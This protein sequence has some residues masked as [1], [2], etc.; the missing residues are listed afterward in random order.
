[1]LSKSSSAFWTSFASSAPYE[2]ESFKWIH[3]QNW[4]LETTPITHHHSPLSIPSA[5]ARRAGEEERS[6]NLLLVAYYHYC[7]HKYPGDYDLHTFNICIQTVCIL[8]AAWVETDLWPAGFGTGRRKKVTV[9]LCFTWQ[10]NGSSS[11]L[12]LEVVFSVNLKL[13]SCTDVKEYNLNA[14]QSTWCSEPVIFCSS[15]TFDALFKATFN[16]YQMSKFSEALRSLR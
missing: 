9:P 11:E 10:Q 6:E 5:G 8:I 12:L 14:L 4:A 13:L 2:P 15:K 1:M 7:K 3:T 16:M